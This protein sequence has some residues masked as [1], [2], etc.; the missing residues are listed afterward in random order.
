MVFTSCL[1][2]ALVFFD[3]FDFCND[4][5]IGRR[6]AQASL[7]AQIFVFF[8]FFLIFSMVFTT[9]LE[10]V[11]VFFDFFDFCKC[12]HYMISLKDINHFGGTHKLGASMELRSPW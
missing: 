4:S 5:H 1:Q 9:F 2:G 8:V 11:L 12:F 3:L 6:L 7:F 10:G